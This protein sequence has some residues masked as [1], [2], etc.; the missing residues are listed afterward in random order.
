MDWKREVI[1]L[2]V[3]TIGL[4]SLQFSYLVFQRCSVENL[5]HVP[6]NGTQKRGKVELNLNVRKLVGNMKLIE[7]CRIFKI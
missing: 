1:K 3:L 4:S 5:F 6:C 2:S 7:I